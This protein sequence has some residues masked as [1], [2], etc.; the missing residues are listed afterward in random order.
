MRIESIIKALAKYKL[1]VLQ[2]LILPQLT[3][4]LLG[5][6]LAMQPQVGKEGAKFCTACPCQG[7]IQ[8]I[9]HVWGHCCWLP[10]PADLMSIV[11]A[12]PLDGRC[13]NF[14]TKTC[15][16]SDCWPAYGLQ[17]LE[18]CGSQWLQ[19]CALYL[20]WAHETFPNGSRLQKFLQP[21]RKRA[22]HH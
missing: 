11:H 7:R 4:F 10:R 13:H 6:I 5:L 20:F 22:I 17:F 19:R 18:L 14:L 12:R 3:L 2:N 21:I 15:C 8:Y 9:H 16:H 1:E